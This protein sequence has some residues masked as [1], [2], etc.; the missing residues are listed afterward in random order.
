M[1]LGSA[2]GPAAVAGG[3]PATVFQTQLENGGCEVVSASRRDQQASGLRSPEFDDR[4]D[5]EQGVY[6]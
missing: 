6:A 1:S 4:V 5:Y 2:A 3:S